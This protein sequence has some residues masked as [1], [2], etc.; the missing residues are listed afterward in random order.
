[1]TAPSAAKP[2]APG[3]KKAG[4]KSRRPIRE[5]IEAFA[6]AIVLALL[7]KYFGLEAYQIPTSSM[8]PT[9]MGSRASGI[10]D[11]IL[12]DKIS[13]LFRPPQRWDI[14]V[15]RYPLNT[16]QNYVKRL[17]G[18]G[19]ETLKIA[20]GNVYRLE[21]AADG[22]APRFVALRKPDRVQED[23]WLLVYDTQETELGTAPVRPEQ[24]LLV[25]CPSGPGGA[26]PKVENRGLLLNL[27]KD[28]RA[29][30]AF[31]NLGSGPSGPDRLRN[32]YWHGYPV[33]I[34]DAILRGEMPDPQW[35][36]VVPVQDLRTTLRVKRSAGIHTVWIRLRVEQEQGGHREFRLEL[37]EKG[38]RLLAEL[39]RQPAAEKAAFTGGLVADRETEVSLA[40]VDDQLIVKVDGTEK[41]RF[42]YVPATTGIKRASPID[43]SFGGEGS[44]SLLLPR[45]RI[46]R[47]IHYTSTGIAEGE[48]SFDVPAGH[49]FMLGDNTMASEDGR[50]WTELEFKVTNDGTIARP[51][52]ARPGK[53]LRGNRRPIHTTERID[54]DENP[55]IVRRTRQV[56]FTDILGE[57]HVFP[58]DG[59]EW[60]PHLP[61]AIVARPAPFVPREFV[62]GRALLVFWPLFPPSAFR[63]GFVR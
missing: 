27:P 28:G 59:Q 52:D 17:W 30:V 37:T 55:V 51:D 38:G 54:A 34:Q 44:G 24:D 56:V 21:P 3:T 53:V 22:K 33:A 60:N 41:A 62:I 10:F 39:D 40:H 47:D 49:Y 4:T 16:S 57:E 7:L 48:R 26:P 12:V 8:Q 46:E 20:D 32:H 18:M 42:A 61:A 31:R 50:A 15:F 45:V 2:P 43:L 58:W 14:V 6:V 23:L 25:D 36:G 5:N 13:Q 35:N 1:M 29:L 19:P 9:L 11:R 63:F